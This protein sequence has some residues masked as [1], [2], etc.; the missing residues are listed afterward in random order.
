VLKNSSN[1]VKKIFIKIFEMSGDNI[2]NEK[3]VVG[4]LKKIEC[5]TVLGSPKKTV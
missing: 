3:S 2:L 5:T 1:Q 4:Y